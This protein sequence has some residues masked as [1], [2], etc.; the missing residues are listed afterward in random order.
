M[1]MF[2]ITANKNEHSS[3]ILQKMQIERNAQLKNNTFLEV[4]SY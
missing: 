3:Q 1:L 4:Y 2:A